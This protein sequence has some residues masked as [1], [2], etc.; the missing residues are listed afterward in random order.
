MVPVPVVFYLR[1]G[2]IRERSKF[3]PTFGKAN[4]AN[5]SP[6]EDDPEKDG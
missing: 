3:A 4:E 2:K 1:G 6:S 5:D